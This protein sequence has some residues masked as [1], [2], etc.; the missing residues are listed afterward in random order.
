MPIIRYTVYIDGG[1]DPNDI[2]K[3]KATGRHIRELLAE[4]LPEKPEGAFVAISSYNADYPQWDYLVA[5][6]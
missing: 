3:F 2:E 6:R 1:D 5:G 4:G